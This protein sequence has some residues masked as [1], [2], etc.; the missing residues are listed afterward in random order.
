MHL[1]S[2]AV[3]EYY[4]QLPGSESNNNCRAEVLEVIDKKGF[5]PNV[6]MAVGPNE[7]LQ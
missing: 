7:S 1:T 5:E 2:A 6:F 3:S 4:A